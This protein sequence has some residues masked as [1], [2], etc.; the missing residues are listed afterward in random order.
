MNQP[1]WGILPPDAAA[2]LRRRY[3]NSARRRQLL[4]D[5]SAFPLEL[6][7]KPPSGKQAL[8][9]AGH[10]QHFIQAWR[11]IENTICTS[12]KLQHFGEQ[13][14]PQK[15]HFPD[16]ESLARFI[17]SN[18]YRQH[19]HWQTRYTRL[20]R[21]CSPNDWQQEALSIALIGSLHD[22]E[23]M[24]DTDFALLCQTIPQLYP[25]IG[26]G[27]YL[28]ALPL[29]GIHTKFIEQ[30]AALVQTL[31]E[32]LHGNVAA[33]GLYAWLGCQTPPKDWLLV[34]P[35]C[36]RT[37]QAL[38]GLPLLRLPTQVLLDYELP[39]RRILVIENEQTCLA[40]PDTPETI[41]VSGGGKNL[42]WM[43]AS[44]LAHKTIAYWGDLD[45][46]GLIMLA[47]ARRHCPQLT[48]LLTKPATAERYAHRMSNEPEASHKQ[49]IP[50]N[51]TAEE[52]LLWHNLHHQAY[53]NTRLEQE[54]IDADHIAEVLQHW[55]TN[56]E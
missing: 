44:W 35:L 21:A 50:D 49:P 17:G 53:P 40:L 30:H 52:A 1:D 31:L 22:L 29:H 56:T 12:R 43:Q 14:I 47:Q 48:T 32:A 3:W 37:R 23:A 26:Q 34:R 45:S 7:L 55:L 51:L 9:H 46:D 41:A 27:C 25:T 54:H 16:V 20:M 6:G 15:L 19:R 42:V 4:S 2:I 10:F 33:Q 18:E 8:Q 28:R 11:G 38:S 5:S 24:T 13:T 39:S 36:A